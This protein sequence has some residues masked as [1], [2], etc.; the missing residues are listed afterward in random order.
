[1][2][3]QINQFNFG[4]LS[5][6]FIVHHINYLVYIWLMLVYLSLLLQQQLH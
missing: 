3:F 6:V 1:M 4:M 5:F 2:N